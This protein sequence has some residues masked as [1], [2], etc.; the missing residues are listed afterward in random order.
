MTKIQIK[1]Y[2]Y[3]IC[4]LEPNDAIQEKYIGVIISNNLKI[5]DQCTAASKKANRFNL[6]KI[7]FQ[8][9]RSNEKTFVRPQYCIKFRP[10]P[11]GKNA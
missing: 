3:K 9:A 7:L 2:I 1:K 5:S 8:S 4:D 11:T 10:T 6:K